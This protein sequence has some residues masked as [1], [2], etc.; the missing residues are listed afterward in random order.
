MSKKWYIVQ[1]VAGPRPDVA[2]KRR[3]VGDRID[4][5]DAEATN[6]VS[7]GVVISEEEL[8]RREE[9][10]KGAKDEDPKKV[11]AKAKDK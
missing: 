1:D 8:N 3:R 10:A 7:R 5:T 9:A 6:E 11:P 4:L 2:G